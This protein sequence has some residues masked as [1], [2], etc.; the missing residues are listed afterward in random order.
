MDPWQKAID[1]LDRDTLLLLLPSS[2]SI[3]IGVVKLIDDIKKRKTTREN[4]DGRSPSRNNRPRSINLRHIVYSVMEAAFEFNDIVTQIMQFDL[5][6]YGNF[7]A[8][9]SDYFFL[10]AI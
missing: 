4:L 2:G 3:N 6:K 9:S 10:R 5:T 8:R 1:E 7:L